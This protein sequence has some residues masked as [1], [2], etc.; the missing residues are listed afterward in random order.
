[1]DPTADDAFAM[2]GAQCV[3]FFQRESAGQAAHVKSPG[4][5]F[6]VGAAQTIHRRSLFS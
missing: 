3:V 5:F 2:H 6:T 1:V 4:A